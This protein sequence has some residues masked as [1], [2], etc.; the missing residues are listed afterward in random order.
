MGWGVLAVELRHIPV[1]LLMQ[2]PATGW[3]GGLLRS[4]CQP[5][6]GSRP[7]LRLVIP[8]SFFNIRSKHFYDAAD[9]DG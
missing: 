7:L 4:P 1:T 3:S 2:I 8:L 6:N 9:Q 5:L